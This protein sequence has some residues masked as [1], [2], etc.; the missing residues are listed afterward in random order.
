MTSK[1]SWL[2]HNSLLCTFLSL[3]VV[4]YQ[5]MPTIGQ[6][7][8]R[9]TAGAG[10]NGLPNQRSNE[11]RITASQAALEIIKT[12]D[13]AAAEPGDTV[14]YRLTIRNT[15]QAPARNITITDRL[16][17]GLRFISKSLKGSIGNS[18]VSLTANAANNRVVTISLNS[19]TELPPQ[20][21]LNVAYAV[22]VTPDAVRGTGR[23]LAQAQAGS[24]TSNQASH[25]LRIRPGILSDCGTIIG[26]VFVDKNFDGEQQP[27]EPGVPNAVIYMDDGNRIVTDAN[28]LFS[29]ANVISGY[30]S[31][32][33][34]LTSLPGYGLAPNNYFIERNSQSR[35]VKLA[36]SSLARVN[37]GVTPAFS[38]GKR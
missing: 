5:T 32:T 36:P 33:L 34:D 37:F 6:T 2:R 1:I 30:R 11:V 29:L 4:A 19:A 3:G 26:R 13:R 20:G 24:L 14:I 28:G 17:L 12:G 22:E 10:A 8:I 18:S 31:A 27:N 38:G 9:N 25:V 21:V 16:P 7:V 15:G 35:M 23:N